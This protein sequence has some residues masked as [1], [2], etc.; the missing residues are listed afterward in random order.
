[1]LQKVFLIVF[2]VAPLCIGIEGFVNETTGFLS[3]GAF[4]FGL[5][6]ILMRLFDVIEEGKVYH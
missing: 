5:S 4:S 2:G 3:N 6:F 1:M